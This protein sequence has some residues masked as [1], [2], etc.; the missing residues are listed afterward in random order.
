MAEA[1][2]DGPE[3]YIATTKDWKQRK[4]MRERGSPRG[5]KPK[6]LSRRDCMER[7]L[8]TKRGRAIY[9]KRGMT[10]EPVF[11][12]AKDGR[13]CDHLLMRGLKLCGAEWRLICGTHNL[14]KLWR[15]GKARFQEWLRD[16]PAVFSPQQRQIEPCG[17]G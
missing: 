13:G 11:G 7:K 9:R 14:L 4:A 8:L 6:D 3:L 15:I 2:S 16:A 5:R 10:V 17:C 1:G 12:Q